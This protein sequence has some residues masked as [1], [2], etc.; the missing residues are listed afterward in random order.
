MRPH[1]GNA[2]IIANTLLPTVRKLFDV[3]VKSSS[4]GYMQHVIKTGYTFTQACEHKELMAHFISTSMKQG[5]KNGYPI[6]KDGE[7]F[8]AN[9]VYDGLTSVPDTFK[10]HAIK[11]HPDIPFCR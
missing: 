2:S 8:P 3:P 7:S 9:E 1:G 10:V 4:S 6:L 5:D 11:P